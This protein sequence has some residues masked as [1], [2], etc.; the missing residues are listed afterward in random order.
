MGYCAD[1]VASFCDSG[2]HSL[3]ALIVGIV[4]LALACIAALILSMQVLEDVPMRIFE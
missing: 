2:R 1:G 4:I 3:G